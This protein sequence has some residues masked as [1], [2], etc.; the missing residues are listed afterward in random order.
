MAGFIIDLSKTNT[1]PIGIISY[2]KND[3]TKHDFK[4]YKQFW[5]CAYSPADWS[6][7]R[8]LNANGITDISDNVCFS[9]IS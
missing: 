8:F 6:I 3:G 9:Y 2:T 7:K 1:R 5:Q 4:V